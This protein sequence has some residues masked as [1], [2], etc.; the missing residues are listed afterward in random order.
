VAGDGV[1]LAGDAAGLA[2]AAS[3]EG[4]LPAIV[5]GQL[6]AE[7]ILEAR[8]AVEESRLVARYAARLADELGPPRRA[9]RLPGSLAKAVGAVLLSSPGFARHAVL[10]RWFLHR[11]GPRTRLR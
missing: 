11:S 5:S 3:G 6:A 4:I 9:S 1:L 2:F 7:T 10:D 8:A